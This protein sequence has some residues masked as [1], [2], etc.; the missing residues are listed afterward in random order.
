MQPLIT[1][2]FDKTKDKFVVEHMFHFYSM[3]TV[4]STVYS[5]VTGTD[6]S[7]FP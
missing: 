2:I 5:A 1:H 7:E 4:Q 6:D 3:R